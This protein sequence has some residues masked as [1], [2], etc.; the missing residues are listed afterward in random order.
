MQAVLLTRLRSRFASRAHYV[1]T[2]QCSTTLIDR[3]YSP[4]PIE[5]TGKKCRFP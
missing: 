2:K 5:I 1:T 4:N 3:N